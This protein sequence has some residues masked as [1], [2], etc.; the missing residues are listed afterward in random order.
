MHCYAR[1]RD[2]VP[3]PQART[4]PKAC[5]AGPGCRIWKVPT[6]THRTITEVAVKFATTDLSPSPH[7]S[8]LLWL[9]E[10]PL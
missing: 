7:H 1:H 2:Q 6:L 4:P 8:F 9:L 10:R 3:H 5:E